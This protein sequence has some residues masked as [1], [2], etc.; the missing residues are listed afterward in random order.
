MDKLFALLTFLASLLGCDGARDTIVHRVVSDGSDLLF[1]RASVQ[2]GVARLDC[3]RSDSGRCHYL[4]LPRDC[5]S[6]AACGNDA[7]HFVVAQGE[8]RQVAG[9]TSFRLCVGS[10][11]RAA[12][13]TQCAVTSAMH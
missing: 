3:V 5:T 12:P 10:D 6:M 13:P 9:L 11:D 8:S 7:R 4:V 2:D 1:S